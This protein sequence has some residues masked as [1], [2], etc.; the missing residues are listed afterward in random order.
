MEE[1]WYLG[2]SPITRIYFSIYRHNETYWYWK[3]G[4]VLLGH[5]VG[6]WFRYLTG[7]LDIAGAALLFA[8]RW[9]FY[10]AIILACSV[11]VGTLI[12]LTVLRGNPTWAARKWSWCHS[13]ARYSLSHWV[14]DTPKSNHLSFRQRLSIVDLVEKAAI[15]FGRPIAVTRL[16]ELRAPEL[17]QA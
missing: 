8:P 15:S 11:G 10:G 17:P 2:S 5:R 6:Q 14:A 1:H 7:I 4:R 3:H 16:R 13:S 9:T 12:S